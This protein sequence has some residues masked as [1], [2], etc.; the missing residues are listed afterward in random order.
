[1]QRGAF[2]VLNRRKTLS[3]LENDHPRPLDLPSTAPESDIPKTPTDRDLIILLLLLDSAS[4][5]SP[6]SRFFVVLC[7]LNNDDQND[8]L[9]LRSTGAGAALS[10]AAYSLP[11]PSLERRK[12]GAVDLERRNAG[13]PSMRLDTRP[14]V[15]MPGT[16][17]REKEED[18]EE[19]DE[20]E[21][22]HAQGRTLPQSGQ[23]ARR[24]S[25]RQT[26]HIPLLRRH[27]GCFGHFHTS[28]SS[29]KR[30]IL[31]LFSA[32]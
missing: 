15:P 10:S 12:G 6:P 27:E 9:P 26:G 16:E 3:G 18:E 30:T 32:N 31:L 1:M 7:A 29:P 2:E 5:P 4:L 24:R 25:R 21:A 8:A 17:S 22:K 11:E 14:T 13:S 28:A 19:E 20:D 23:S